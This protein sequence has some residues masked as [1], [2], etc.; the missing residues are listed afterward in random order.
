MC[1]T[2]F[3]QRDGVEAVA[4]RIEDL[5]APDGARLLSKLSNESAAEVAEIL[6]PDTA[7]DIL[8]EMDPTQAAGVIGD[9]EEAEAS[10]VLAAMDPDDRVDILEHVEGLLHDRLVE[11]WTPPTAPR[12]CGTSSS[13]SR[14]PPAAS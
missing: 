1:S 4:H 3:P 10:M 2:R 12:E 8:A 11:E 6:D 13:T 5:P 9:M 14:T 7:G